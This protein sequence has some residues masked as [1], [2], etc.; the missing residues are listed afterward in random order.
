MASKSMILR[1]LHLPSVTPFSHLSS[2]QNTLV[3]QFLQHKALASSSSG[4]SHSQPPPIP[5][6][7]TSQSSPVYTLG[8]RESVSNSLSH[9]HLQTLAQPLYYE[10]NS[11]PRATT[12]SAPH[13]QIPS[14]TQTLRGGQITFHGPG[15][16]LI[17]PVLDLKAVRS[18]LW[19]RGL[20]ARC[21][22]NL[23]EETTIRTLARSGVTGKRTEN[24]GVWVDG[25]TK[26]A[27]LGVHLRRNIASFGVGLNV[28]T[29]LR[30]FERIVAC[31]LVGKRMTSLG[32]EKGEG[33][34]AV[35]SVLQVADWWAEEFARCLWGED[36]RVRRVDDAAESELVRDLVVEGD[37]T[38]LE[39][40][41]VEGTEHWVQP[42]RDS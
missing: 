22:V 13:A 26:I 11:S 23:L 29:D 25:E 28:A 34:V 10:S 38:P 1:H 19:P 27:A 12:T 17:W 8:R 9:S 31:G 7:L 32:A 5:F 33:E 15:Q 35:A 36:G 41:A 24:P 14:I 39:W 37:K 20:T 3:A 40:K 18:D 2:L 6:L 21:Y 16:L 42:L 4:P 30:W